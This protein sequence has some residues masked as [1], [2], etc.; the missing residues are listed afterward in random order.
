[1]VTKLKRMNVL[2]EKY[3]G[4]GWIWTLYI[5]FFLRGCFIILPGS[6]LQPET[7]RVFPPDITWEGVRGATVVGLGS[8]LMQKILQALL[9]RTNWF[10]LQ[11]STFLTVNFVNVVSS[12]GCK[13]H[14]AHSHNGCPL[15]HNQYI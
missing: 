9:L 14:P 7:W 11:I 13:F 8:Q 6:F 15:I 3:L 1:M 4:I 10:L 2:V 12:Y 5:H